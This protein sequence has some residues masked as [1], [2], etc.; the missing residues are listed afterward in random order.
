MKGKGA[1]DEGDS[2]YRDAYT[3]LSKTN[4]VQQSKIFNE[5]KLKDSECTD[6]LNKIIFLLNQVSLLNNTCQGDDFPETMKSSMFFNVTKLFQTNP[7]QHINLRRLIYVFIKELKANKN[8]VFI[9]IQCLSKDIQQAENDM[10]K[11][12]ALRVLTKIIDDHYVQSLDKFIKQAL[13]S[14]SDHVISA[15][16]VSMIELYKRGG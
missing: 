3:N 7:S 13:M 1:T 9:V 15:A 14:K 16:I 4:L 10:V 8:E 2:E 5:K 6:L 11:A 12:N